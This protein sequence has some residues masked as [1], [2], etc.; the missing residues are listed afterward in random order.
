MAVIVYF[1][2]NKQKSFKGSMDGVILYEEDSL[3]I[4]KNNIPQGEEITFI[5]CGRNL[6]TEKKG[7]SSAAAESARTMSTTNQFRHYDY[8]IVVKTEKKIYFIP[9]KAKG[10][11]E[12]KM[13]QNPKMKIREYD[14]AS[15]KQEV[16]KF[17]ASDYM[18]MID[19][20][21][22]YGEGAHSVQ[23]TDHFEELKAA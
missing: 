19:V 14:I 10:L 3:F 13:T 17:H 21:F 5:S 9:A 11:K 12:I 7:Y 8:Y 4:A 22:S 18:P 15:V 2:M 23:F 16:L 1:A 20:K 6:D